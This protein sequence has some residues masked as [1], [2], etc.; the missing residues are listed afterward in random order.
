MEVKK[1]PKKV[2]EDTAKEEE[3]RVQPGE[4]VTAHKLQEE[5]KD[6]E[7]TVTDL[8]AKAEELYEDEKLF[9]ASRILKTIDPSQLNEKH[10]TIIVNS[11]RGERTVKDLKCS[12]DGDNNG[13][14]MH[15]VSKGEFPTLTAHKLEKGGGKDMKLKAR[16]ETPIDRS[17][18]SPIISVLNETELYQTWLPSWTVP[19]FRVK[20]CEKL[21]QRGRCSQIIIL[22]FEVPWPIANREVVLCADGFEDI[23]EN[24]DIAIII[25]SLDTGDEDGLVPPPD[26]NSTV[27]IDVDGGFLFRKCPEDH[28]AL[29]N[30]EKDGSEDSKVLVTFAASMNPKMKLLPQSFL[31]FLVKV[32]FGFAWNILLKIARDVRDGKR[33]DHQKAIAEKRESLYDWVEVK[34]KQLLAFGQTD[35]LLN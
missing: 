20:K 8:L 13:W 12:V 30:D 9:E 18:L 26:S 24:G 31:N 7:G 11:K 14:V 6:E 17:M 4:E 29:L 33:E 22:T 3:E 1:E 32:A 27:R 28:P 21:S 5:K 15:G 19:K 16:C 23:D 2:V 35:T 10:N 25:Q 34:L